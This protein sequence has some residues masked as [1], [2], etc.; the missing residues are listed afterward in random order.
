MQVKIELVLIQ[1]YSW[2][3]AE[4]C[5]KHVED[6]DKRIIEETVSQVGHLPESYDNYDIRG[7]RHRATAIRV[8]GC[9]IF[10]V[11]TNLKEVQNN[12]STAANNNGQGY[13]ATMYEEVRRT[14]K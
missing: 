7:I 1:L 10:F 8:Q 13:L 6:S 14:V 11:G 5:S 12:Y 9:G 3:W 4:S 2:G